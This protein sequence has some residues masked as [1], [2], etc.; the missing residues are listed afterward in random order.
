MT[1]FDRVLFGFLLLDTVL[2]ALV[3]LFYLPSWI[4]E[5]QFPITTAVA[6]VT[7]P[8]LVAA[9]G[10]LA[11]RRS[12]A[13]APLVLWFATIFVFGL[14]GPGGD[15]MLLGDDWRTLLLVFSGTLPSALMLGIVLGK[16]A[17]GR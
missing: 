9:C 5:V 13:G 8:L 16:Q 11:P 12:V 1:L 10:R 6:A 17:A 14:F 2:L 4:G 3:E 15:V 7:T